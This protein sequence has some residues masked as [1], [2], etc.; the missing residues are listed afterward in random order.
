MVNRPDVHGAYNPL[1]E[2]GR[3]YTA[4]DSTR[5]KLGD[6]YTA[7]CY[8]GDQDKLLPTP[9][10]SPGNWSSTANANKSLAALQQNQNLTKK[11]RRRV[12]Q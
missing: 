10:F 11:Q 5:N 4:R 7:P 6:S 8:Q 12:I 9:R 2:R 1:P 3:E